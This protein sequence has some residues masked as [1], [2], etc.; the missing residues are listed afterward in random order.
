MRGRRRRARHHGRPGWGQQVPRHDLASSASSTAGCVAPGSEQLSTREHSAGA[1]QRRRPQRRWEWRRWP[2]RE[3]P[4]VGRAAGTIGE[5][6]A[7]VRGGGGAPPAHLCAGGPRLGSQ[8]RDGRSEWMRAA[9]IGL[10]R[11]V[12]PADG[13]PTPRS[14]RHAAPAQQGQGFRTLLPPQAGLTIGGQRR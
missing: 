4:L 1:G 11:P 10:L 3:Q 9:A 5:G 14:W 13:T 12:R 2:S 6:V 8:A 7:M